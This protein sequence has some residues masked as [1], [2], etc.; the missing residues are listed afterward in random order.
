MLDA[1]V[2]QR[3]VD[4]MSKAGVLRVYDER[5]CGQSNA[6]NILSVTA[7]PWGRRHQRRDRALSIDKKI[8]VHFSSGRMSSW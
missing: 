4:W 8:M 1:S 3:A 6:G 2:L 7:A 5:L